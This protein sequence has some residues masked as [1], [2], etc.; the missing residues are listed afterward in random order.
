MV[1]DLSGSSKL[2]LINIVW[3]IMLFV[4]IMGFV[5]VKSLKKEKIEK[6]DEFD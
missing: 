5:F 2:F 3:A 6:K 1:Q 4:G